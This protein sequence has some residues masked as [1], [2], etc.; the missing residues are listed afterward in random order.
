MTVS[1]L[2]ILII[3]FET[4]K[5]MWIWCYLLAMS[6]SMQEILRMWSCELVSFHWFES[7]TIIWFHIQIRSFQSVIFFIPVHNIFDRFLLVVA[8][9]INGL[10]GESWFDDIE[11]AEMSATVTILAEAIFFIMVVKIVTG[12]FLGSFC[13]CCLFFLYSDVVAFHVICRWVWV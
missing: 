4:G 8:P 5:L 1:W 7:F 10:L 12:E 2:Y 3:T 9:S 6:M 13:E 11:F